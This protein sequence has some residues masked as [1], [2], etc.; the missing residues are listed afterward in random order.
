[1]NE[2][3]RIK[4]ITID[5]QL[6]EHLPLLHGNHV[7]LEQIFVNL[8]QNSMDAIEEQGK[9]GIL[10]S[11]QVDN[12]EVLITYSDTGKGIDPRMQEKIFEPFFTTKEPGKGTG[13]GLSIVYGIIQEHEGTITCES[14]KGKGV[15]FKI[16]LPIYLESSDPLSAP[17]NA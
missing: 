2:R 10:L 3:L 12:N 14:E 4:N 1:M 6:A 8:I 16:R 17:L 9:G 15:T 13:I 5:I 11:A 7:K